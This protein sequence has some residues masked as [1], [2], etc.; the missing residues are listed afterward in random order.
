MCGRMAEK[1]KKRQRKKADAVKSSLRTFGR[2]QLRHRKKNAREMKRQAGNATILLNWIQ[3]EP[4]N[5]VVPATS[6]S[7]FQTMRAKGVIVPPS[8]TTTTW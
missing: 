8:T 1:E 3:L 5:F 4:F 7:T 6:I 2:V